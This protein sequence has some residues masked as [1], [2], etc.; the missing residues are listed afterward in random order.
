MKNRERVINCILGREIDRVPYI[1]YFGPWGETVATW[2][3]EGVENPESAWALPQF[4]L[5]GGF[6]DISG[7]FN[8]LYNPAFA[9]EVL[10]DKGER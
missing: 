4:G 1:P 9:F 2:R 5:D 10:E 8:L 3:A 6:A 7:Y